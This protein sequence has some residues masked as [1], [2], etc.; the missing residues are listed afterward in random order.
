MMNDND[1]VDWTKAVDPDLVMWVSSYCIEYDALIALPV[2]KSSPSALKAIERGIIKEISRDEAQ[3]LNEPFSEQEWLKEMIEARWEQIE[4]F[5]G[6][7]PKIGTMLSIRIPADYSVI[8]MREITE[9]SPGT[10]ATPDD[11]CKMSRTWFPNDYSPRM[12]EDA[13]DLAMAAIADSTPEAERDRIWN[14]LVGAAK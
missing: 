7:L 6:N 3:M 13:V 12:A 11:L 14:L 2:L 4:Q 5:A 1:K 10:A 9:Y 8:S